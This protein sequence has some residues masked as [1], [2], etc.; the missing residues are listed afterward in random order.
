MITLYQHPV[1]PVCITIEA[2][3]QY[4]KAEHRI[5]NLPYSDRR[6][7]VEKTKGAYYKVALLEDGE[8]IVWEPTDL[9]RTSATT[10][11]ADS[12]GCFPPVLEGI[13]SILAR[14]IEYDLK[15]QPLA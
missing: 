6:V 4:A 10:L 14:Y 5:V 9:V 7:I 2:I 15:E 11:T 13:Q 3:L 1:S 8:T 12:S